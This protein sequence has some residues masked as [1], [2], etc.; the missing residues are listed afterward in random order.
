MSVKLEPLVTVLVVCHAPG[1]TVKQE[2]RRVASFVFAFRVPPDS[3]RLLPGLAFK[4]FRPHA[5]VRRR[6]APHAEKKKARTPRNLTL[7]EEDGMRLL[8]IGS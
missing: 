5:P 7:A 2:S 4:R 6:A 3:S 8:E 1:S